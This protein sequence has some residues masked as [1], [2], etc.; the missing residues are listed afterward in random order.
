MIKPQKHTGEH[1]IVQSDSAV[2]LQ[3]DVSTLLICE[4]TPKAS[5]VV[6]IAFCCPPA[7]RGE[8][9]LAMTSWLVII[10]WDKKSGGTAG[11][12]IQHAAQHQGR[13]PEDGRQK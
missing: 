3:R 5:T 8:N 10:A 4:T 13:P 6:L 9:F 12:S 7:C 11:V 1:A 2:F